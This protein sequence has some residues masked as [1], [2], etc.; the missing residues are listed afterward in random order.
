M[1]PSFTHIVSSFSVRVR[2]I[3]LALIPV[4]GFLANGVN[5]MSSEGKVATAFQTVKRSAVL[6]EASR[7][8]QSA[9]AS[10]R[11]SAKDF[12]SVPS[13]ALVEAFEE[14]QNRALLS[15]DIL[16][17]AIGAE[18]INNIVQLRREVLNLKEKFSNLVTEQRILGFQENEGLRG[19]LQSEGN[20]VERIINEKMT[21]LAESDAHSLLISLL[22][23]KRYEAEHRLKQDELSWQ[24]FLN[25]Y[26]NLPDRIANIDAAASVKDRL[27]V[28]VKQ[29]FDIFAK[30]IES[31]NRVYSLRSVIDLDSKRMFPQADQIIESAH[32][33]G[34]AA[35]AVLATSQARTRTIIVMV[36]MAVVSLGLGFSWLIGWS[37]TRP[38]N[39]LAGVMKRL[40]DGDTSAKI[41]ATRG[42]DE[43]GAMARTVIVFRDSMIERKRLAATQEE[44]NSARERRSETIAAT[45]VRFEQSVDQ[46]LAKV[47]GA[48]H[49]LE[50][51]S[52]KLNCT[53]DAVSAEALTAENRVS[54]A[55]QTV[56]AAA[57]SV[58][59]LATSI[60]EIASQATKSTEVA[61]RAVSEA[62]R[63]ANTM[64]E[65]DG[66]ATRIGEVIGLIQ[67]IAG[68]T[69]LLALNAT[70]EAARAGEAGRGF[71]VVA[72]EV[73]SLAGQTA[74]ATEDIAEQ[75]GAIQSAAA[76][77]AHAIMQVNNIIK[78][79]SS[80]ASTVASTVEEQ[81]T[82]VSSIAEGVNRASLEARNG[83]EAMSRVAGASTDARATAVDV[84]LLADTLAVEAESLDAEVRQFLTDVQAA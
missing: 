68:Q 64:A 31:F 75:I 56:T 1:S 30:W 10:M 62:Q 2:I 70:I 52:T 28:E 29:Y 74:K 47:R 4:V 17:S 39:G 37:I 3:V 9:I 14:G 13:Q 40:A 5:F 48:A 53:A 79:M 67:A 54:A 19:G 43:I 22:I 12:A 77:A 23:M 15:L 25:E 60:G 72:V 59:E 7:D 42:K 38:L 41:P 16:Q 24:I 8:F 76:D 34:E 11:L 36:S 81:N 82:A 6:I 50:T 57:G 45:I 44:A 26:K 80:I 51:T 83:A 46:A 33:S 18:Q 35:S 20:D 63:T 66:A 21:G 61:K 78:E 49:R 65:L 55:S 69:N 32:A 73:K 71:A 58:E 84:K 27:S